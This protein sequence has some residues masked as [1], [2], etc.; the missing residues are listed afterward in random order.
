M[1]KSVIYILLLLSILSCEKEDNSLPETEINCRNEQ[2]YYTGGGI[3]YLDSIIQLD[4]LSIGFENK[5]SDTEINQFLDNQLIFE[6]YN[7][8]FS[9]PTYDY[10]YKIIIRKFK[11]SKS[12]CEIKEII[13]SLNTNDTVSFASYTYI[14]H[15]CFG[16]DCTEL[17][18]YTNEFTVTV[19]DS[20]EL[21]S[22]YSYIEKTKTEL[23]EEWD[24]EG[25]FKGWFTIKV[26][27]NSKGSAL[28]TAN[29][30]YESGNFK[31]SYPSFL[32]YDL[33]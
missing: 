28:E 3:I 30:F 1:Q 25:L 23:V 24:T 19:K 8:S 21:D 12:C 7:S 33:E 27:K 2:F 4:Y 26:N 5:Y 29:Y 14:G 11:K 16:W 9:Y 15:A 20:E 18:S 17:M 10:D 32:F 13:E 31:Y 22:L 6:N